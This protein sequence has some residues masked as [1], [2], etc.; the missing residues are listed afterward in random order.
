MSNFW[1]KP[2]RK[3]A[4]LSIMAPLLA[5]TLHRLDQPVYQWSNGR[6]SATSLVTGLPLIMVTTTGAK[7]GKART[8][9]LLGI[10]YGDNLDGDA[11]GVIASNW[12]GQRHPAWYHNMRAH[13][14]VTVALDGET[15]PYTARELSG[16]EKTAVWQK[17]TAIYPGYNAYKQRTDREIP[18]LLLEPKAN[19]Q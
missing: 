19:R 6:F 9:P 4:S 15:T 17:A 7:S 5:K 13:P 1:H 12:G 18:V 2:F 10:P 14:D 3:L 11:L 16:A 8:V